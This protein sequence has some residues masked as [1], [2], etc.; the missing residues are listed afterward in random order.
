MLLLPKSGNATWTTTLCCGGGGGGGTGA[1]DGG[2]G[3]AGGGAPPL[4]GGAGGGGGALTDEGGGGGPED[5]G[6]GG[7]FLPL[8]ADGAKSGRLYW[9]MAP[10]EGA[11]EAKSSLNVT[12]ATFGKFILAATS[13]PGMEPMTGT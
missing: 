1:F 11:N 7:A 8:G 12:L 9:E 3:G 4:E 5:A 10:N 6:G 13:I 2:G